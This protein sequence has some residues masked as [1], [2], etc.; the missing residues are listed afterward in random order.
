VIFAM[1]FHFISWLPGL[2]TT[3]EF[4]PLSD[5]V[6]LILEDS[7]DSQIRNELREKCL[8]S[9][10]KL[11]IQLSDSVDELEKRYYRITGQG[12]KQPTCDELL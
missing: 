6:N 2:V 11:Q 3:S 4:N 12:L 10:K 1:I 5:K 8:T 7:V 9:D